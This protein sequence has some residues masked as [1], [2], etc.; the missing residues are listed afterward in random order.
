MPSNEPSRDF[1]HPAGCTGSGC[2]AMWVM[3]PST[4]IAVAICYLGFSLAV[5]RGD[6]VGAKEHHL[7]FNGKSSVRLPSGVVVSPGTT[8]RCSSA[9]YSYYFLSEPGIFEVRQRV[10][11]CAKVFSSAAER[12]ARICVR[13][14]VPSWRAI[15]PA[16]STAAQRARGHTNERRNDAITWYTS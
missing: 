1:R 16:K 13:W 4:L 15:V 11:T 10:T 5:L 2:A 7:R 14:C 6:S 3:S 8:I 9:Q 12:Q